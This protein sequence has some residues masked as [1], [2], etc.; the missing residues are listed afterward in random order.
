MSYF[1]QDF[2]PT[3]LRVCL[4]TYFTYLGSGSWQTLLRSLLSF[5]TLI[6]DKR[7][8]RQG[9]RAPKMFLV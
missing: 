4:T 7:T 2:S 9:R 3:S 5:P 6:C 1:R 8:V